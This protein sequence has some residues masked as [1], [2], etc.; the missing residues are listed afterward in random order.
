[1]NWTTIS[2][3]C[4]SVVIPLNSH[5]RATLFTFD[6]PFL[7]PSHI[8]KLISALVGS[9]DAWG[10]IIL[11]CFRLKWAQPELGSV[12]L[13]HKLSVSLKED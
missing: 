6:S 13:R 3:I 8:Q 11:F 4:K 10:Q 1:M 12:K 9:L 2:L 5:L 7:F